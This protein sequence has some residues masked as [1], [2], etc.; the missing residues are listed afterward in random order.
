MATDAEL[1]R[2][3]VANGRQRVLGEFSI[4]HAV[5]PLLERLRCLHVEV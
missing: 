3:C 1:R 4:Q 5:E 2:T